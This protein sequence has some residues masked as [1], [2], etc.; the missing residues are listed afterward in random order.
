MGF[1]PILLG[2]TA[3]EFTADTNVVGEPIYAVGALPEFPGDST[4]E[5]SA[6]WNRSRTVRFVELRASKHWSWALPYS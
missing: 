3:C 4:S 1:V 2:L 5:V 6:A